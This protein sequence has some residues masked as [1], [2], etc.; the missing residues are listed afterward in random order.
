MPTIMELPRMPGD[1]KRKR[2]AAYARVSSGKDAMLHSLAAQVSRYGGLIRSTPGWE[3]AGV[4]SD[5]GITG[6][7]ADRRGFESMLAAAKAGRIDM[8][9]TKSVS[10]FARNTVDLLRTVRELA[11]LGVDVYFEEQNMH[12]AS[13]D[14]ELMLSVIA[15]VAQE[16]SRSVSENVKWRIRKDF[17]EGRPTYQ[18]PLGYKLVNLEFTVVPEEAETVREI[19]RRCIAGEGILKIARALNAEGRP[20]ICG[21]PWCQGSVRS[22]LRNPAYTGDL[23]LQRT[24]RSDHISKRKTRNRGEL[25]M[26]HI[27]GDHEAIVTREDFEAAQAAMDARR[28]AP[29]GKPKGRYPFSG[30][31]KCG[32]CGSGYD[33]RTL[34]GHVHWRCR[35]IDRLGKAGCASRQ[36]PDECLKE[37]IPDLSG[38]KAIIALP[39]ERLVLEFHDGH[40]EERRWRPRSRAESWTPEM[41]ERA[42]QRS[43]EW[44]RRKKDGEER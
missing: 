9:I 43:N 2:V 21:R 16:E 4:F 7:K 22:V 36:I 8:V 23:T 6:T 10:R 27:E 28:C 20:T 29:K 32:V 13:P 37:A 35:T 39:G 17:A 3:F 1:P 38:V 5:E 25:P 44:I 11:S 30:L 34:K 26:Y 12:S 15:S 14:G 18:R 31:I 41:K 24:F 19:F 40:T 33:R 42:R